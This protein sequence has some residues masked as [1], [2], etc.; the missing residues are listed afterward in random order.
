MIV[1]TPSEETCFRDSIRQAGNSSISRP[2][3]VKRAA[4]PLFAA[5]AMEKPTSP[6]DEGFDRVGLKCGQLI[7]DALRTGRLTE[8][9]SGLAS[10]FTHANLVIAPLTLAYDFLLFCRRHLKPCPLLEIT[11]PD[12]TILRR[13][14][15]PADLRTD[16]PRYHVCRNG[17]LQREPT[18]IKDLWQNDFVSFVSG[19][20]SACES[21]L[22]GRGLPAR[23]MTPEKAY[24]E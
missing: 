9:T 16:L 17:R 2:S 22:L 12:D 14:D 18:D 19:C 13:A 11:E 10:A 21:E 4:V 15:E 8:Q 1:Y 23:H 5:M 6:A 20:S 3:F 7:T 24:H